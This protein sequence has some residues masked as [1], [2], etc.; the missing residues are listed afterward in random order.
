MSVERDSDVGGTEIGF[1][2]VLSDLRTL[3][4]K[5]EAGP[6]SLEE[7]LAAFEAGVRLARKGAQ[8]LDAAERRVEILL[9]G[10]DGEATAVPFADTTPT[11]SS[12]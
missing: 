1:D 9:R 5:L 10:E 11:R 7:S 8:I 12:P 3:V 6:L 4:E 2:R